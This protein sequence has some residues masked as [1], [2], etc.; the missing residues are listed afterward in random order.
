MLGK[1][2]RHAREGTLIEVTRTR[3]RLMANRGP[4]DDFYGD[5]AAD[6]EAKRQGQQYWDDQQRI[7]EELIAGFPDGAKVLD[8]PFGTGRF[9]D[10]YHRKSMEVSG[11]EISDD[12]IQAAR[13]ARGEAMAGYDVRVGDARELPWPDDT[14]DLVV[15]YRFI[16]SIISVADAR[17]VL[18]ELARV[19]RDSVIV[20]MGIRDAAAP[21]RTKPV[22]EK[23]RAAVL[24]TEDE[25]RAMF[26]E[27]GLEVVSIIPQYEWLDDGHRCAMVCRVGSASSAD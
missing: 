12:M 8:V 6:Y 11:L 21:A 18:R 26:V 25:V 9:V 23:E 20:D 15:C 5:R 10:V 17:I 27:A 4:G 16:P 24:M 19:S 14:F 1:I 13:D 2:M 22:S 7:A 3:L